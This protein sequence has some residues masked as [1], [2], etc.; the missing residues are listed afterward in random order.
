VYIHYHFVY[1]GSAGTYTDGNIVLTVCR[2]EPR[3]VEGSHIARLMLNQEGCSEWRITGKV[4]QAVCG[5]EQT[6]LPMPFGL[7]EQLDAAGNLDLE[8]DGFRE[9]WGK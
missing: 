2:L 1:A 7:Y 8:T 3:I 6:E 4:I 9:V 5:G